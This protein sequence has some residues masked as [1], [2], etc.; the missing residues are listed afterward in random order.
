MIILDP[1]KK[2][3][4]NNLRE[5]IISKLSSKNFA[6][7]NKA[8]SFITNEASY[9]QLLNIC[10]NPDAKK[11]NYKTDILEA[12]VVLGLLEQLDMMI[13]GVGGERKFVLTQMYDATKE[14]IKK[15]I[16]WWIEM[17]PTQRKIYDSFEKAFLKPLGKSLTS[18]PDPYKWTAVGIV[19]ASVIGLAANW[20]YKNFLSYFAR[21]CLAYPDKMSKDMCMLMQRIN[22][23]V[24]SINALK[25]A[26]SN[27]NKATQPDLCKQ[28]YILKIKEREFKKKVLEDR[29]QTLK[30]TAMQ[31]SQSSMQSPEE[32]Y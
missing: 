29:L 16:N 18:R 25:G 10:F 20:V 9:N 14:E 6:D 31:M 17:S 30:T 13:E 12:I 11:Y 15:A 8:I 2:F 1:Y 4:E 5:S 27:C 7:K 22:A 23:E 21:K 32:T 19:G 24:A 28:N 26:M 3:I